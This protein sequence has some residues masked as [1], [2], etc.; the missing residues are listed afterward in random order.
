MKKRKRRRKISRSKYS[1]HESIHLEKSM[2]EAT[3]DEVT[4]ED[5]DVVVDMEADEDGG[6]MMTTTKE[7][8]SHQEVMGEDLQ[9]Q[10][11]ISHGS[12]ATIVKSLGIMLPNVELLAIVKLKR[13]PTML[14][15]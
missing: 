10:G 8:K 11:T 4:I 6:L 2:V 9:N 1:R 14:K 12:N 5:V 7:E 13:R 15:K 3:K